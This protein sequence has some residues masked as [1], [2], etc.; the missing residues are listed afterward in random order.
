MTARS[1]RPGSCRS[2]W[3]ISASRSLSDIYRHDPLL[4]AIRAAQFAGRCG[5]C[6]Y[7][8]LCG[9]SRARAYAATGDPL[10]DDPACP[11]VAAGCRRRLSYWSSVASTSAADT[12]SSSRR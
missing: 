11:L 4:R 2:L 10:G 1:T 12:A 3:A 9:G 7:A 5:A 6:D 8:D